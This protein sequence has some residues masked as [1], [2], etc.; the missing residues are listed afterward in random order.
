M[1]DGESSTGALS[2]ATE[3]HVVWKDIHADIKLIRDWPEIDVADDFFFLGNL[4]YVTHVYNILDAS[5]TL[6]GTDT[7]K[8]IY[9]KLSRLSWCL[10]HLEVRTTYLKTFDGM[11][12]ISIAIQNISELQ[13]ENIRVVLTING[14]EIIEPTENLIWSEYEG[15]QGIL[16]RDDDDDCDVGIICELFCLKEDGFVH[17]EDIPYNPERNAPRMPIMTAN[18]YG[19]PAKSERDYALELQEFIASSN[20]LEYYEFDVNSLRPGEC[21]WLCCGILIKPNST[22]E[23]INITYHIHSTHSTGDLCGTF[24]VPVV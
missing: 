13:D 15:I 3:K 18:G 7:E 1:D 2:F 21:K 22:A 10:T 19:Y 4:K 24:E 9:S 17:V 8:E 6:A 5:P 23:S 14:G 12:F 11:L 16:C 20:G